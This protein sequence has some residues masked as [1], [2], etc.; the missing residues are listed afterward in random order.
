MPCLVRS[1]DLTFKEGAVASFLTSVTQT[2]YIRDAQGRYAVVDPRTGQV[3]SPKSMPPVE[4]VYTEVKV[5]E[6]VHEVEK[7]SVENSP[8]AV[9]STPC[10]RANGP[11]IHRS[12]F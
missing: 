8:I 10:S 4:F 7:A 12:F 11:V 6:E 2:G 3:F 1:T 5:D 9:M